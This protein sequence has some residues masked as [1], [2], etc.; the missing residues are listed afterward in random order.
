MV[1]LWETSNVQVSGSS[2][3]YQ[4]AKVKCCVSYFV[5]NP[6]P[7][8]SKFC[9]CFFLKAMSINLKYNCACYVGS[10]CMICIF[11]LTKY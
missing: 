10:F 1:E 11:V 7:A 4:R 2:K 3:F 8:S 5:M 6:L 9:S